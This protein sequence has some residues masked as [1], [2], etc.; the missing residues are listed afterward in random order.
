MRAHEN[1]PSQLGCDE[2]EMTWGGDVTEGPLGSTENQ[3]GTPRSVA[4][5]S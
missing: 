1:L 2:N 4:A 5:T 3:L